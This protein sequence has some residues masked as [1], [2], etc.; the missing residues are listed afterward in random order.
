MSKF[1]IAVA[2]LFGMLALPAGAAEAPM[3]STQTATP[4]AKA[5][6]AKDKAAP[7]AATGTPTGVAVD[8]SAQCEVVSASNAAEIAELRKQIQALQAQ[9][10]NQPTLVNSGMKDYS[11]RIKNLPRGSYRDRCFACMTA[12]DEDGERVLLCTCPVGDNSFERLSI[13]LSMCHAEEEISYCSGMLMC[14]PCKIN[15]NLRNELPGEKT[16]TPT[17]AERLEKFLKEKK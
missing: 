9:I 10:L 8:A 15:N 14:G 17:D 11:I 6:D 1:A 3:V 13:T 16:G 7:A 2:V 4:I 12:G 5:A